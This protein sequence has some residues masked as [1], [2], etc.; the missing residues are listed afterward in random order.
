MKR[1][2]N[3]LFITTQGSYLAREG[4]NILVKVEKQ[5]KFCIPIHTLEGVVC[6][7][8]VSCSPFLMQLCGENKVSI[9]FL[10]LYGHFMARV[11]GPISGNVFL[12]REQYRRADDQEKACEIVRPIVIGKIYNSRVVINRSIRDH[13]ETIDLSSMNKVSNKLSRIIDQVNDSNQINQIRGYEGEAANLYFSVF[14]NLITS[15]K[16]SFFFKE[17]SRRP[18]LDPMNALLSFVYTLLL[19]D[20]TSALEVVGLD[21]QAGF[22]HTDRSGRDSLAL[23]MMEEFRPFFA[24]RLV[25]SLVN[26][27]QVKAKGFIKTESGAY[28]MDDATRKIVLSTYQ[29]RKMEEIQHP[30]INEKIEFGLIPYVQSLLLAQ[31][32]R[33][34]IDGYPPYLWK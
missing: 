20:V 21:P 24:D 17:R 9:S 4:E 31:Y 3:T 13:G 22:L 8:Q 7:G 33:G 2:L 18:P 11:Q 23:D 26:R 15:Q 34:D 25:L 16:D 27:Q 1:L 14:D 10:T 5:T 12:R 32:L 19:H 30:F 28:L 6:F 29:Q